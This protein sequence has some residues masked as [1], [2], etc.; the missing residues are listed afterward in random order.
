MI[1]LTFCES[2]ADA[3]K[4]AISNAE[5][6]NKVFSKKSEVIALNLALDIG[7]ISEIHENIISRKS[8]L[9]KLYG[10][11]DDTVE[12][13]WESNLQAYTRLKENTDIPVRMWLSECDPAELCGMHFV[14]SVLA[15]EV[16]LSMVNI[17]IHR[18]DG[19]SVTRY[20]SSGEV[21]A[22]KFEE[23][24]K[25]EKN[26]DK[27]ERSY[28]SITW[29]DLI[30]ENTPLRSIVNGKLIGVP[31][32]IYDFAIRHNL[33]E[34]EILSAKLIGKTIHMVPGV[35]DR[36]LHLRI[37]EMVKVGELIEISPAA[38]DYPYSAVYKKA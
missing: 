14:C 32:D 37:C 13:L 26:L 8:V 7:D 35:G 20:Y 29:T 3:L 21:E 19:N 16:P 18:N 31:E 15:E 22:E 10:E 33:P 17:S 12:D 23:F 5:D 1:E 38:Y 11:Y 36:W 28:Y 4:Y 30:D 2:T 34:G 24:V 27:P 25:E 9:E 6:D